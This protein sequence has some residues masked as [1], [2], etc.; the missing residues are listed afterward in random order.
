MLFRSL[1]FLS[2]LATASAVLKDPPTQAT[3]TIAA[4]EPMMQEGNPMFPLTDEQKTA[5][6]YSFL[7]IKEAML[8][9]SMAV[10]A[11]LDNL[12]PVDQQA[13]APETRMEPVQLPPRELKGGGGGGKRALEEERA[14]KGGGGG[15]VDCRLVRCMAPIKCKA[16]EKRVNRNSCCRQ[17]H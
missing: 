6:Y 16:G 11:L 2:V 5:L 3:A 12:I 4:T 13:E 9:G 17:C 7:D 1:A 8:E 14:L 10:K 15:K